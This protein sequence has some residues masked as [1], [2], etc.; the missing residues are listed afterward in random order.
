M[1]N[2]EGFIYPPTSRQYVADTAA[3]N[4]C[5]AELL[6]RGH[7]SSLRK[8]LQ[9]HLSDMRTL[10][11]EQTNGTPV[12]IALAFNQQAAQVY[13]LL[14]TWTLLYNAC[15]MVAQPPGTASCR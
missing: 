11:D 5:R 4:M 8:T 15:K 1:S 3:S 10:T 9:H 6:I 12:E 2:P 13:C 14:W 7:P